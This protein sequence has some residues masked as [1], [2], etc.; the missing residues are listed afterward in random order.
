M[1]RAYITGDDGIGLGVEYG[2][3]TYERRVLNDST[4]LSAFLWF[5]LLKEPRNWRCYK[6]MKHIKSCNSSG[7]CPRPYCDKVK[8]AYRHYKTCHNVYCAPCAEPRTIAVRARGLYPEVKLVA[9][10]QSYERAL[11]LYVLRMH[12]KKEGRKDLVEKTAQELKPI[13]ALCKHYASEVY[14]RWVD[15]Q[16]PKN[17]FH[18]S[19]VDSSTNVPMTMNMS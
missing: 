9:A 2:G 18:P 7:P 14:S 4:C 10:R 13:L 16:D 17:L 11:E 8:K 5:N 12:A 15:L 1:D 19:Q 3:C 6:I